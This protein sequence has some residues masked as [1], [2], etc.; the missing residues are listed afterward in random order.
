MAELEKSNAAY[1]FNVN[2]MET[3]VSVA[4]AFA[5]ERQFARRDQLLAQA[6]AHVERGS[7]LPP[8]SA[9]EARLVLAVALMEAG[10]TDAAMKHVRSAVG[11]FKKY[12]VRQYN[13]M[14]RHLMMV[15]AHSR[16]DSKEQAELMEII[17]LVR[18]ISIV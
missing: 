2:F 13:P 4:R 16:A 1:N 11:N 17:Q 6:E 3:C 8:Q 14:H 12:P 5:F 15:L 18:K 10:R 9:D 7:M